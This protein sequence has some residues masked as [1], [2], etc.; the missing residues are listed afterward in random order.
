MS[1]D[2]W[3]LTPAAQT[4]T[5]YRQT[6]RPDMSHIFFLGTGRSVDGVRVDLTQPS[7]IYKVVATTVTIGGVTAKA[8]RN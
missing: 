2:L 4:V 1:H 5:G 6:T 8:S 3:D 7:S